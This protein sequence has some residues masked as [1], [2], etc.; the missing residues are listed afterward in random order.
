M[1]VVFGLPNCDACR[2]ALTWLRNQ[3]IEYHFVDY[4]KN[5][6]EES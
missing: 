3:K 4:R 5:V 1:I 2:K 6:L